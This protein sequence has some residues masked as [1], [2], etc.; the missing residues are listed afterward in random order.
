M[1]QKE[2]EDSS[3]VYKIFE[4]DEFLKRL[5]KFSTNDKKFIETKLKNLI[6]DQLRLEPHFGNN[7]KKLRGYTPETWRFRIGKYR[8]FY[9]KDENDKILFILT[10]EFRKDAY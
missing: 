2:K 8:L 9:S 7:I 5:V 6:Y 3:E 10:I 1:P 4:T